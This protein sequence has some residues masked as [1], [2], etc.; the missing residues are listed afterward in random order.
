MQFSDKINEIKFDGSSGASQI[1][2]NALSVLRTFVQTSEHE[3]SRD[4]TEDFISI[5]KRLFEARP[6]MAS[7]QN[8]MAQI[9]F[10][11]MA[12]DERDVVTLQN[13]ALSR[14]DELYKQSKAAVK[15]SAEHA[16]NLFIASF[17]VVTCSYSSTICE[18]FSIAKRQGKDFKVFVAESKIGN[19]SYGKI[20]LNFL[21]KLGIPAKLFPDS[22]ID[23]YVPKSCFVLVGADSILFDGSIING[24]P[25][26]EVAVV[27]KDY[28]TPFYCVCE[29]IK[30]NTSSYLGKSIKLKE[31]FDLVPP[32]LITGIITERGILNR[33]QI[34][35]RMKQNSSFF[36]VFSRK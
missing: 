34:V 36:K 17:G 30:A 35:E 16:T 12:L 25:T 9:A 19:N 3:S 27:A 18:T 6:N 14:I 23:K 24:T 1:A 13:F 21:K 22:E 2:R 15:E 8:L 33:D 7:I 4:F 26:Y 29:T 5:S 10:E 31:G 20:L 28:G 32:N 11:I